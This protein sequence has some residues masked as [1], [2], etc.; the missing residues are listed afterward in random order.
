MMKAILLPIKWNNVSLTM[1][2]SRVVSKVKSS[3]TKL[4]ATLKAKR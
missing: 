2:E 1:L 4:F 3:N